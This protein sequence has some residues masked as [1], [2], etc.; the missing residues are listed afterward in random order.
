MLFFEFPLNQLL[1]ALPFQT[2]ETHLKRTHQFAPCHPKTLPRTWSAHRLRLRRRRPPPRPRR[3]S[4][5]AAI[6]TRWT[7]RRCACSA[8]TSRRPAARTRCAA[9]AA[10]KRSAAARWARSFASTTV[11]LPLFCLCSW[12]FSATALLLILSVR[13]CSGQRIPMSDCLCSFTVSMIFIVSLP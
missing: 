11:T 10:S 5:C 7:T 3:S 6:A 8:S 2:V 1:S 13:H 9:R 12:S 4:P